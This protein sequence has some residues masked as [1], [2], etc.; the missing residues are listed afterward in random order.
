MDI[1]GTSYQSININK[2]ADNEVLDVVVSDD[3]ACVSAYIHKKR[4]KEIHK[5]VKFAVKYRP[6]RGVE[7][8]DDWGNSVTICFCKNKSDFK[9]TI[10]DSTDFIDTHLPAEQILEHFVY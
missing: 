5:Y 8:M 6:D 2:D 9:I 3:S 1:E 7:F 4:I 10:A